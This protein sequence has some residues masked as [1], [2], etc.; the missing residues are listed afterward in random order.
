MANNKAPALKLDRVVERFDSHL[1][2]VDNN[3]IILSG[4]YGIGKTYFLKEFF[5]T[6]KE[7]FNAIFISP[8]KYSINSSDDIFELLKLDIAMELFKVGF[9]G[10]ESDSEKLELETLGKYFKNRSLDFF[11]GFLKALS[12][13][14]PL[15]GV[16][17]TTTEGIVGL[18]RGYEKFKDEYS[19]SRQ[20]DNK[21]IQLAFFLEQK[22]G[23]KGHFG[24][25]DIITE[26]IEAL[27]SESKEDKDWVL[28]VDD[29]D[30]IDPEHIFRIFNVLSAHQNYQGGGFKFGFEKVVVVCD[31][32]NLQGLYEHKYGPKANFKG[33][34]DKF[35]SK[36]VFNFGHTDSVKHFFNS[37]V[38]YP[39]NDFIQECLENTISNSFSN[40]VISMRDIVRL[41][42]F[43]G[44]ELALDRI[45]S[46]QLENDRRFDASWSCFNWLQIYP[47]LTKL[48]GDYRQVSRVLSAFTVENTPPE[49]LV[50]SILLL[51]ECFFPGTGKCSWLLNL[52]YGFVTSL[53]RSDTNVWENY[54]EDP[55]GDFV[56]GWN[57]ASLIVP[58]ASKVSIQE[59][60]RNGV[61]KTFD[62]LFERRLLVEIVPS[63]GQ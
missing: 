37:C 38:E 33:Y 32:E 35:Y 14:N 24:E 48:T 15:F 26:S 50:G 17:S 6:K 11:K 22:L 54:W 29:F 42:G 1:R 2:E 63:A 40:N 59:A 43:N 58:F 49:E 20:L 27:I 44:G 19:A 55:E 60:F 57:P 34:I 30:R 25:V 53:E 12:K 41:T 16:A 9:W 52:N 46:T 13:V 62:F 8:L 56:L 3:Y 45:L 23:E 4:P 21:E 28:V 31:F 39:F 18:I 5:E 51:F 61:I 7:N 47:L 36:E 10:L